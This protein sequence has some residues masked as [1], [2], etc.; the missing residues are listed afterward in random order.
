M[1]RNLKSLQKSLKPAAVAA[2]TFTALTAIAQPS[3]PMREDAAQLNSDQAALQ[4]QIKRLDADE[5]R[6]KSD[7]A[8]G[9]MSA[10]SKDAYAVYLGK[11][12]VAG[13]KGDIAAD[14]MA[15]PQM[16]ADKAALQRQI[17]RLEVAEAR[18]KSDAASG[19]MAAESKDAERAYKDGLAVSAEKKQLGIDRSNVKSDQKK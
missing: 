14:K 10:E 16:K 3:M 11:Q 8:S 13:E 9:R 17:K 1:I 5:A 7:T 12:A 18:L 15:G 4:R 2:F 6:L 19:K